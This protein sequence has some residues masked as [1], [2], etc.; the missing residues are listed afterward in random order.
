MAS[1]T[2]ACYLSNIVQQ[3]LFQGKGPRRW[4]LPDETL[5]RL[6]MSD[7]LQSR[8]LSL[9]F[10]LL[11]RFEVRALSLYM[12]YNGHVKLKDLRFMSGAEDLDYSGFRLS[13]L[14]SICTQSARFRRERLVQNYAVQGSRLAGRI[15]T[16]QS[17]SMGSSGILIYP[18]NT[19][20]VN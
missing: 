6:K 4:W 18:L 12:E 3:R 10:L 9:F 2:H 14:H 13:M 19:P 1:A 8:A 11:V 5:T 20:H 17:L 15:L 7:C 16:L